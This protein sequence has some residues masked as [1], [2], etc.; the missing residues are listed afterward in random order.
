VAG[1]DDGEMREK[2]NFLA[3]RYLDIY[4]QIEVLQADLALTKQAM[5]AI[6]PESGATAE[7][8][9]AYVS[10]NLRSPMRKPNVV[11][12][13]KIGVPVADFSTVNPTLGAYL[14][15]AKK[16]RWPQSY[17]DQFIVESGDKVPSVKVSKRDVEEDID[18]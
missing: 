14:A 13:K 4:Q 1:T 17:T 2:F 12:L 11:A 5:A 9:D 6:A 16:L 15:M 8:D 10:Y 18:E 7:F 3:R